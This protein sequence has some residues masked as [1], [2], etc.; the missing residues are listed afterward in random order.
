MITNVHFLFSVELNMLAVVFLFLSA[1]AHTATEWQSRT[2]YQLLTDRFARNNGDTSPC[3]DLSNYCGGGFVGLMNNLD[4]IQNMGFDAIWLSPVIVN[5]PTCYHGYCAQDFFN[6]NPHFGTE[7]EFINLISALHSRNMWIMADVVANHV[8]PIGAN[9]EQVDIISPFNETSMYHPYCPI[10]WNNQTSVEDCW[11]GY[12][13]DLNQS[14][15]FVRGKLV[16]WIQWLVTKFNIDGLRIDTCLEVPKD[17]W[18]EFSAASGVYTVCEVYD[19]SISRNAEY[20]SVV[21]G[22]LNYPMFYL[23]RDLFQ[24]SYSMY[25]ARTFMSQSSSIYPNLNFEGNF[26]DNHDNP[27]FLYNYPKTNRLKNALVWSLTWPGIPIVY[28]GSEQGFNGGPDPQCREPLWPYLNSTT[29]D[30]YKFVKTAITYRKTNQIW[31]YNWVERY[32]DNNFYCYSRGKFL[33]A[34]SNTDNNLYYQVSY[35]PYNVGDV[36]CNVFY[37]GDCVTVTSSGV[38]VYLDAGEVKLYQLKSSITD[39]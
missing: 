10:D 19:G 26:V 29:S 12:L 37:T 28:Y 5:T 18:A 14:V 3:Q 25:N 9:L 1:Y 2:I 20:Q 17:F 39:I 4:Y 34:F 32:A 15:P 35:N 33:M 13:P 36:V 27:R 24:S 30:L 22:T 11:L 31:N 7:A 8:G 21:D 6:I 16:Y 23:M 38:P